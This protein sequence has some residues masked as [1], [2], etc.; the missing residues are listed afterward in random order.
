MDARMNPKTLRLR[1]SLEEH[2]RLLLDL[3]L[4]IQ[5]NT[6]DI[7]RPWEP[8]L[9]PGDGFIAVRRNLLGQPVVLVRPKELTGFRGPW[10][11]SPHL[12]IS[13]PSV[14]DL[15]L[16]QAAQDGMARPRA[17]K[18]VLETIDHIL[19]I[20]GYSCLP[21]SFPD[22]MLGPWTLNDN[23]WTR[24]LKVLDQRMS[25]DFQVAAL[26]C[27]AWRIDSDETI[28]GYTDTAEQAKLAADRRLID[29]GYNLARPTSFAPVGTIPKAKTP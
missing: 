15:K 4:D 17:Y 27:G 23:R 14:V 5:N 13:T 16:R 21:H 8:D 25:P 3:I 12:P 20:E 18:S 7:L 26:N 22:I 2:P 28:N 19:E 9:Q 6:P 29:L 11:I 1:Q 10:T 24:P